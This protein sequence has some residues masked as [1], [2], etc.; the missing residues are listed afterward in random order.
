MPSEKERAFVRDRAGYRCEYCRAPE[1]V[2]G[3]ALHIE[4]I[5]P[6]TRGGTDSKD[7]L[8]LS[9]MPCNR[10]KSDHTSALNPAS[11]K[12][13]RL[14][15]PRIDRWADHFRIERGVRIKGASAIGRGT[16]SRLKLNQKRQLEARRLWILLGLFP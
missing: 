15:N 12:E 14:F 5:Q 7:N 9:C 13:V 3:Y 6:V 2:T 4:H 1:A 11:G 8:A 10:G 16:E